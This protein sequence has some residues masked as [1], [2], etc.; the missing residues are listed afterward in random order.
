MSAINVQ[1]SQAHNS[2]EIT[3]ERISLIFELREIWLSFQMVFILAGA[4][5]VCAILDSTSGLD[6]WSVTTAPRYL[7]L[8]TS[9]N[10]VRHQFGLSL[11]YIPCQRSRRSTR[12]AS[13][14]SYPARPSMSSAKRTL[15]IALPPMLTVPLWSSSASV[16]VLSRKM[17]KRVGEWTR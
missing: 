15:V 2:T 14:S 8:S 10:V 1:I 17:L 4:A 12:E 7:K 13:S 16:I 6:P 5:V 3:R 11:H 9:S